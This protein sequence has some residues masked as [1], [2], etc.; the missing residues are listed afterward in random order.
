MTSTIKSRVRLKY[1]KTAKKVFMFIFVG[2]TYGALLFL[3]KIRKNKFLGS[4]NLDK[5]L[6]N[7][8][9][10]TELI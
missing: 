3:S 10:T 8:R 9:Q 5:L 6:Q 7:L 2:F 1:K 4:T